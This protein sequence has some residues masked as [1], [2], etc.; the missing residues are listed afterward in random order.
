[1]ERRA[2]AW[3]SSGDGALRG[4][5]HRGRLGPSW[6]GTTPPRRLL[7]TSADKREEL[8]PCRGLG[9]ISRS[10]TRAAVIERE[11]RYPALTAY[12]SPGSRRRPH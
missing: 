9:S 6:P 8:V 1:M 3:V 7:R 10:W 4:C 12:V 2:I 11:Q 5:A